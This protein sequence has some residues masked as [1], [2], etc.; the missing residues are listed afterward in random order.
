MSS[1]KKRKCFIC[2]NEYRYCPTCSED[3]DKPTWYFICCSETCNQINTILSQHTAGRITT[4][5]AKSKL[6]KINMDNINIASEDDRNHIKEILDFEQKVTKI[7]KTK[8]E[9]KETEIVNVD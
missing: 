8:K 9:I 5:E 1:K 4:N 3:A 2:G 7:S 6:I